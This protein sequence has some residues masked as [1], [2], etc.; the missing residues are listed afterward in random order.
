M[1]LY[2]F[3]ILYIHIIITLRATNMQVDDPPQAM[4]STSMIRNLT[5]FFEPQD[6]LVYYASQLTSRWSLP[7]LSF[8]PS[9]SA[10][11]LFGRHAIPKPL[12]AT[13][14]LVSMGP[15]ADLE[16]PPGPSFL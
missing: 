15:P 7:S 13:N 10:S 1:F 3:R 16:H 12:H 5:P 2:I 9:V 11:R 4:P 8:A 6:K 14:F